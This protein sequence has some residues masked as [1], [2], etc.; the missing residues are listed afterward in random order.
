MQRF[1]SGTKFEVIGTGQ[2]RNM[3]DTL[4]PCLIDDEKFDL[5][6]GRWVRRSFPNESI[7]PPMER[8]TST[9]WFGFKPK[10][11]GDRPQCWHVDDITQIS[12]DCAEGDCGLVIGHRWVTELK[13]WVTAL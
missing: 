4:P 13:R 6:H 9:D 7:C 11:Y 3:P 10:Y 2:E 8:D 5:S 1:G 12:N